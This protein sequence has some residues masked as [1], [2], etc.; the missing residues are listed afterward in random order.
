MR[1]LQ[2]QITVDDLWLYQRGQIEATFQVPHLIPKEKNIKLFLIIINML[3]LNTDSLR[4][5]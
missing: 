4:F 1:A 3:N 5:F 2:M